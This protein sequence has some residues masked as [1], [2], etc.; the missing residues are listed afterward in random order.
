MAATGLRASTL[1]LAPSSRN[2][3]NCGSEKL[4]NEIDHKQK[5]LIQGWIDQSN[6]TTNEYFRFMSL[7]IAF[8]ALCYALFHQ[9][10]NHQRAD[11]MKT[12]KPVL[13]GLGPANADVRAINNKVEI[14][15]KDPNF[16]VRI[17]IREKYSE[18]TIFDQFAE[19]N[20]S[21]YEKLLDDDQSFREELD[22]FRRA[23]KKRNGFYVLNLS[24]KYEGDVENWTEEEIRKSQN[25]LSLFDDRR[26]LRQ[27]KGVLYQ[28]R[29]NVFHGEKTPGTHNDDTIVRT[30]SPVLK[31]LLDFYPLDRN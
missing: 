9:D 22:S 11:L 14:K 24:R 27:L 17:Q 21:R 2:A 15:F 4:V 25:A 28:V 10:A 29:N 19:A 5:A 1:R 20:Q 16:R 13:A 23:I 30:A 3:F 31:R 6:K 18:E 8:N 12:P 7:W 26:N